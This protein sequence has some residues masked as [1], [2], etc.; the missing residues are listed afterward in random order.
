MGPNV[1]AD[2]LANAHILV[3]QVG[4]SPIAQQQRFVAGVHCP[5]KHWKFSTTLV[6]S[7]GDYLYTL[8]WGVPKL[9]SGSNA[10]DAVCTTTESTTV[11]WDIWAGMGWYQQGFMCLDGHL[12]WPNV[13]VYP[14]CRVARRRATSTTHPPNSRMPSG[15]FVQELGGVVSSGCRLQRE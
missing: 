11:E 7:K 1:E 10:S 5:G 2:S 3:I 15:I 12:S 14:S 4:L 6:F 13:G 9:C 8:Q